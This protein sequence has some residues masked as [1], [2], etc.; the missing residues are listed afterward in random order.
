MSMASWPELG[1]AHT[2]CVGKVF[3]KMLQWQLAENDIL[4]VALSILI[5]LH[6]S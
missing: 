4:Q 3:D 1:L 2:V 5:P 6:P